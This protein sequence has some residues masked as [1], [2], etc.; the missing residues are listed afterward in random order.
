MRRSPLRWIIPLFLALQ[1]GLLWIQ[2]AQLHRQ[3]QVLEALR[4]DIQALTDA[5]D[6]SQGPASY[7]WGAGAVPA[8]RGV[9]T[10]APK[11]MAVLGAEE[12]QDAASKELQASRDSAQKAVKEARETQSKLSLQENA[13]KVEEARQVQAATRS[14]QGWALGAL[15]L[16]V[17]ALLTRA[18]LQRRG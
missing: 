18:V 8:H 16:V 12:E 9:P 4:D 15:G 5:M 2:G 7:D 17:L 6:S 13:R 3:N 10:A 14:W 1:L 11:K